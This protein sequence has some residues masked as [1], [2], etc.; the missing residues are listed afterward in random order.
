[1]RAAITWPE[2]TA[3][4]LAGG[5]GTRLGGKDKPML[6]VAGVPMLDR[7]LAALEGAGRRIVVGPARVGLPAGVLTVREEPAG[8]GPAA[9]TAAALALMPAEAPATASPGGLAGKG[10]DLV[11]VFAADLPHLTPE[12]VQVLVSAVDGGTGRV[13]GAVFVDER[14]SGSCSAGCGGAMRCGV[15]S[16]GSGTRWASRCGR[17]SAGWSL[18]KSGG[19]GTG[20]RHTSTATRRRT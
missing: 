8:A 18:P 20:H 3:V 5:G 10:S 13:D 1:M 6:T 2:L 4:V 17:C 12:A 19:S 14:G 11:G 9:A 7:V 16:S 15:G